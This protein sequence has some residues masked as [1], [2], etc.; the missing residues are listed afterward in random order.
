MILLY[1]LLLIAA[2]VCFLLEAFWRA[3]PTRPARPFLLAL[4]L[5]FWVAVPMLQALDRV[6]A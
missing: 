5:A 1:A 2:L 3:R 4:G 6:N